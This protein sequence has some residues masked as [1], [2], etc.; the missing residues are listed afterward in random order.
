M[1]R[2]FSLIRKLI[3]LTLS[4]CAIVISGVLYY[5]EFELPDIEALNTVQ[6]QVPLKIFSRDNKLIA[7]FGEKRRI[8]VPYNEIPAPL[9]EA[10]LATEDQRYFQHSGVDLPGLGRAALQL[11]ATGRKTQGGSTITMQVAR[12]FYLSRNKTF[13]RKVR[14]ILLAIKIEHRLSKEK[15]LELYLNKVFLGNRAYGV[16][17]AAAVYYGK[18]LNEL[19]I[20]QFAMIAGLPKAPSTL[21]PLA[22]P[23]AALKRRDHVLARMHE[24]GYI[25][26]DTFNKAINTPLNASY[27]DTPTELKAPY[28]AELVR[29]Q[30]EQMYGDSIYTD[31]FQVYTTVDSRLQNDANVALRN[32]LLAY[33]KRHGY[34]GPEKNLGIPSIDNMDNWEQELK[35][36]P[37]INILQP[38]AVVEMTK[39]TATVLFADGKLAVIPW[40]GMSWARKQVNADYLGPRPS[41]TGQIVSLG[42]VVRVI[43]TPD[44]YVLSQ[45]P[46]AEAGMVAL[47]P[48]NG[49]ILA[50]TGGFDYQTSKF[51]RITHANRQPGSSFKPFIYSAA[52]DKGFT[53]ATVINDAPIVVE[54]QYDNSLW[55]PQN[56]T[57]KFYG[58]TRLR[59]AITKS[60]NLVTIR[61]LALIGM[62]Y[63]VDYL[64][65]F[66]FSP[67]QLP[68]GLSLA[69]GT[70]L[71]TPLQLAQ[72]YAVFANGGMRVVPYV[73][74]TIYN[75]HDQL[76]YQAKPLIACTKNCE[77]DAALAPR[78]LSEQT[79]FLVTSSL[80]DVIE[81]GT[82]TEA[83]SVGR[84]DVAGKTGTTQNQVDAWFAGYNKSLVAI[85]WVGFD[86][87]Q[88]LHE[89]GA[90]AA[91]PAWSQFMI[92]ALKGTPDRGIEQPPGIVSMRINPYTGTAAS[93]GDS[94]AVFEFFMPP[95]LPDHTRQTPEAIQ[96]RSAA[97]NANKND[98]SD[99]ESLSAELEASEVPTAATTPEVPNVE[100]TE[101]EVPE[102]ETQHPD[103][104]A[105]AISESEKPAAP[106]EEVKKEDTDGVG[107]SPGVGVT[108]GAG[109]SETP[110]TT[111]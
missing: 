22:N 81:H 25:D 48:Y 69:L 108:A 31:G 82:A 93:A 85:S 80:R 10:V 78:V 72:A 68:P 91:L 61:L 105:A 36:I 65:K 37:V 94:S 64:K 77:Q 15:I 28:V 41:H 70:A 58:L 51:N 102:T 71:V 20:D 86:L 83:L 59:T 53:L 100:V 35:K 29:G 67:S 5:M 2:F 90:Q 57:H 96:A 19:S 11:I 87:P 60:R 33:D 16:G 14:E 18:K 24:E 104:V 30:L 3:I 1:N 106:Q 27:H 73:V 17:A 99:E 12:S 55:R 74:S 88:S 4:L 13:G 63:T 38:A 110:A 43:E 42:D 76:I 39:K 44:G 109:A 8:P 95:Y 107:I 111:N 98:D 103:P 54:N 97:V 32:N 66:G 75:S 92:Q 26:D 101:K 47:N 21:N 6:L 52:L 40:E 84:N 45:Q 89:Y 46:K 62:P 7:T 34:R 79:A 50:L 9:I 23:T 49:A 56:S